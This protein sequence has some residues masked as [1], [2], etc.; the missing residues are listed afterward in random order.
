MVTDGDPDAMATATGEAGGG[1]TPE[2]AIE[3]IDEVDDLDDAIRQRTSGITWMVW[4]IAI[5]GIFVS[6]SYVGVLA[7]AYD[8]QA[9]NLNPFLWVPWV[10]LAVIV[11]RQ[12]WHSAGLVLEVEPSGL[13]VEGLLTGAIFLALTYGGILVVQ[14]LGVPLLEPAIV[15]LAV[16]VAT[17]LLGIL[18]LTTTS[19]FERWAAVVA[20]AFLVAVALG[21]TALVPGEGVGYAWFSLVAPVAVAVAY[22]GVGGLVAARG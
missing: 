1:L 8:P 3:R 7:D 9:A 16:G 17:G 18:G 6:Y 12:L 5:A 20:G 21:T 22:F 11:S 14:E 2:E 4:G 15:L 13:D 19:S 10:L